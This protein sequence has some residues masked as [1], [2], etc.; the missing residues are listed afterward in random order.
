MKVVLQHRA[1][2][3]SVGSA[4]HL[5][6]LGPG[7]APRVPAFSQHTRDTRVLTRLGSKSPI[8]ATASSETV[9]QVHPCAVKHAAHAPPPSLCKSCMAV[10]NTTI[11]RI[12]KS[13]I[14]PTIPSQTSMA[15][16]DAPT[17]SARV[18][19]ALI[20]PGLIG[21]TLLDQIAA[22]APVLARQG[23]HIDVA[24]I[25]SSKKLLLR[26][27]QASLQGWRDAFASEVPRMV[28]IYTPSHL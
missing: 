16:A 13:R 12:G 3:G 9:V 25:A 21:A 11:I 24:A 19:V 1:G 5:V 2:A 8:V 7:F 28:Y 26:A 18:A 4:S 15:S 14:G 20:G 10:W 17:T 27:P 22:Q 6:A 23:L